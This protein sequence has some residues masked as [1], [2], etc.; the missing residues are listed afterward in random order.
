MSLVSHFALSNAE[1]STMPITSDQ[2]R[3]ARGLLNW[4]QDELATNARVSRATVADF[5]SNTRRPMKNNLL[6]IEDALFAAGAEF[7]PEQGTD[8]VGV[9]FRER[10]LQYNRNIRIEA[11]EGRVSIPMVYAGQDFSCIVPRDV[12]E[13]YLR[14]SG[15]N[16]L[17]SEDDYRAAT[18]EMLHHILAAVERNLKRGYNPDGEFFVLKSDMLDPS[19]Q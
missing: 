6:A 14:L 19:L 3:A 4:T 15:D 1:R 2:S 13:D 16:Q 11:S 8:G 18:S 17:R 9:R 12:L 7:I 10:K 5:E